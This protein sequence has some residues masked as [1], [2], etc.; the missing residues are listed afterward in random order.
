M[1]E[2]TNLNILTFQSNTNRQSYQ[3]LSFRKVYSRENEIK[4]DHKIVSSWIDEKYSLNNPKH[5]IIS[6][7]IKTSLG[8]MPLDQQRPSKLY[9]NGR[10][11]VDCSG[12]FSS[13]HNQYKYND[14]I[15]S[16]DY[17]W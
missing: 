11:S 17:K 2:L 12:L 6:L 13:T 1:V 8:H 10:S 4:I 15:Y 5:K 7:N 14:W 3:H 9:S 16:D